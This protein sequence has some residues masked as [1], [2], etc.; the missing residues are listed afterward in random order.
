VDKPRGWVV[1]DGA[2]LAIARELPRHR[3]RLAALDVLPPAV[4]RRQG[5]ALLGLVRQSLDVPEADLPS[6]APA[7]L[8]PAQR[9][10][11]KVLRD[12]LRNLAG[13]L[14]IA[15]E[16]A[17]TGSELE[18]LLREADGE[19]IGA[20]ARWSGWRGA[21]VVEP[22]RAALRT[23]TDTTP[24]TGSRPVPGEAGGRHE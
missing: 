2:C 5:D 9:Q 6:A 16:A 24:V 19:R 14:G 15:P 7:P 1:D 22:L 10:R 21:A 18:L 17:L 8:G 11:L 4:L 3:E 12:D 13:K 20:P 23:A